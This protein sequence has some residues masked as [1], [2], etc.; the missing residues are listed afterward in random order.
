M[1]RDR[2][3][4]HPHSSLV[5]KAVTCPACGGE[6]TLADCGVCQERSLVGSEERLAGLSF[7]EAFEIVFAARLQGPKAETSVR[8]LAKSSEGTYR[9]YAKAVS[10]F[11]GDIPLC[12]I[13]DGHIRVFQDKR[14]AGDPKIW[15]RKAGRNRIRKE[16]DILI[17]VLKAAN[18]WTEELKRHYKRLPREFSEIIRALE[19]KQQHHLLRIMLTQPEWEWIYHYSVLALASCMS[20]YELRSIRLRDIDEMQAVVS[21]PPSASK[22]APRNRTVPLE[23]YAMIS[24]RWLKDRAR[25]YGAFRPEHYLFPWGIG[26]GHIPN[27][28]KQMT[29]WGVM[30]AWKK[31]RKEA[32]FP[33]LRPYDL[34]HTAITRMAEQG[35][36]I[37]VIMSF[38]GHISQKMQQHYVAISMQTK[39]E[40]A[41]QMPLMEAPKKAPLRF[42]EFPDKKI[43]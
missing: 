30:D 7:P 29:A 43:A 26:R 37:H 41:Q 18:L 13:T 2:D 20:T 23:P 3:I 16:V 38:A 11:V 17:Y 27:P 4:P 12:K 6:H 32:G 24:V 40:T 21:I 15:K 22:N 25:R 31:I 34:R 42:V 10:K 35:V 33:K 28:E 14:A 36:P 19:P 8:Y 5:S 1:T 39:R 9:D